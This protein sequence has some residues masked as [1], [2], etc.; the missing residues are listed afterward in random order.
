MV[1]ILLLFD[2]VKPF[3]NVFFER[4]ARALPHLK[5]LEIFNQLEQ[6][7]KTTAQQTNH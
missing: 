1:T 3:E 5:T 7:E 4:V 2:D 6:Q